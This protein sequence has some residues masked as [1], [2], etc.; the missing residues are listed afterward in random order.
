VRNIRERIRTRCTEECRDEPCLGDFCGP[1]VGLRNFAREHV[2]DKR[3][4]ST[5]ATYDRLKDII[6]NVVLSWH[7]WNGDLGSRP[8]ARSEKSLVYGRGIQ[9]AT[10]F[11]IRYADILQLPPKEWSCSREK[12]QTPVG[13]IYFVHNQREYRRSSGVEQ[14]EVGERV[15][16]SRQTAME[17]ANTCVILEHW[18]S[19]LDVDEAQWTRVV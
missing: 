15:T 9:V 19:E 4:E 10:R 18:E 5:S 11:W 7:K 17:G 14:A 13:P 6:G 3:G 1:R 12:A 8:A 16:P 2:V